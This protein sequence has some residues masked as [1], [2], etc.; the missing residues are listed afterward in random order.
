MRFWL[1]SLVFFSLA[2]GLAACGDDSNPNG[3]DPGGS[4]DCTC[5]VTI[6][7]DTRE[8]T[9][10]EA[11]CVGPSDDDR[12]A[13]CGEGGPVIGDRLCIQDQWEA[14][15]STSF[16]CDGRQTCAPDTYCVIRAGAEP[17][18][19]ECRP[20]PTGCTPPTSGQQWCDCLEPDAMS[21][22]ICD[23]ATGGLANCN[24]TDPRKTSVTCSDF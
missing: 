12:W 1:R 3:N 5:S 19:T 18:Q 24:V 15:T 22:G 8:L 10:G 6:G 14:T 9:C 17:R 4:G 23:G 7:E 16:D 21:A 20:I 2:S 13:T 11:T